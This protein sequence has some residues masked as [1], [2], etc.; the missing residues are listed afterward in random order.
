MLLGKK[1]KISLNISEDILAEFDKEVKEYF[2][3][4]YS[5]VQ[6]SKMIEHILVKFIENIK[7]KNKS[8]L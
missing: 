3:G 2:K 8:L 4:E 1:K 7:Q 6:R 5:R